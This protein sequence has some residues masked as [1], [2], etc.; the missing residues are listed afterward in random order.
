MTI[1][2]G[3]VVR[4]GGCVR[5]N[6]RFLRQAQDRLFDCVRRGRRTSLR[7][8]ILKGVGGVTILKG[9]GG[10]GW[11]EFG[12]GGD[13]A[14]G[15]VEDEVLE[16]GLGGGGLFGSGC[17]CG[18]EAGFAGQEG[19]DDAKVGD[20]AAGAG[21]IEVVGG[22]AAENERGGEQGGGAVLDD[23]EGEGLGG[24]EVAELAGSGC[25]AAAGVVVE[26]EVLPAEG[27][28]AA[29]VSV[30]EDVAAE[31]AAP[32]VGWGVGGRGFGGCDGCGLGV[33]SVLSVLRVLCGLRV[34]CVG[35]H[36]FFPWT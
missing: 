17:I 18:G 3:I 12:D 36:E 13:E 31:V 20:E 34:L 21:V 11:R 8:T 33:L 32:G 16:Q 24:V 23:G 10:V 14:V 4:C 25:G 26:A 30:G 15:F 22:D 27:R 1:L 35:E 29:A 28:R 6:R 5:G 19:G 2:K 9:V 7:M